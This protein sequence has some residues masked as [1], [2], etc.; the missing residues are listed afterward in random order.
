MIKRIVLLTFFITVALIFPQKVHAEEVETVIGKQLDKLGLEDIDEAAHEID[1][2]E[3]SF[4]D[5]VEDI[6]AGEWSLSLSGIASKILRSVFAEVFSQLSLMRKILFIAVLCS[7]LKTLENSFG[8]KA[9]EELGFYV[10]YILLIYIVMTSFYECANIVVGVTDSL[11]F[12][13]EAMI[14]AFIAVTAL[15]GRVVQSGIM[16]PFIMGCAGIMSYAVKTMIV[17][18]IGMTAMLKIANNI[19]DRGILTHLSDLMEKIITIALKACA[20]GFMA[21]TTL[22]KTGTAGLDGIVSETAKSAVGAVPVV[23]KV[24]EGAVETAA[25]FTGLIRSSVGLGTV[26][27]VTAIVFIPFVKLGVIWFI[28]K[29]AAAVI[30]PVSEPRLIKALSAAGDFSA[31]LMAAVFVVAVMF[32]FS[33][34]VLLTAI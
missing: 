10:C 6:M 32:V 9:A 21:V 18:A 16:G 4:A 2:N 12:M 14:P 19:S 5:T 33:A 31:L 30:E 27:L 7:F 13:L 22:Q 24:M 29:F 26:F 28:Y 11:I 1:E 8:G 15:S 17:P 20:F 34:I 25:S 23:G 3:F